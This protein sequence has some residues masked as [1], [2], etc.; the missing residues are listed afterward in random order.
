M[1]GCKNQRSFS[2][3]TQ[4]VYHLCVWEDT[5]VTG[6]KKT[7]NWLYFIAVYF[8]LQSVRCILSIIIEFTED[9]SEQ[10]RQIYYKFWQN[11]YIV[12]LF[13]HFVFSKCF[14]IHL[15]QHQYVREKNVFDSSLTR[16]YLSNAHFGCSFIK[17]IL[18]LSRIRWWLCSL[19]YI[20]LEGRSELVHTTFSRAHFI[21]PHIRTLPSI[22]YLQP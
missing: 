16:F 21:Y 19:T 17:L 7:V 20:T 13:R 12:R 14:Y 11:H 22:S 2:Y 4:T 6:K 8:Y 10:L 18:R 1:F 5:T 15:A 3:R 9:I